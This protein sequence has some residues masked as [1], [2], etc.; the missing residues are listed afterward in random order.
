MLRGSVVL[1]NATDFNFDGFFISQESSGNARA[2]EADKAAEP[3]A[4]KAAEAGFLPTSNS[5]GR[6]PRQGTP[7]MRSFV[8]MMTVV[9][10]DR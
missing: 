10:P 9:S 8:P 1:I 6:W 2:E 4:D 7:V 5:S 3:G